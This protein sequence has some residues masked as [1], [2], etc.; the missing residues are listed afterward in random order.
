MTHAYYDICHDIYPMTYNVCHHDIY[1]RK[2]CIHD[3]CND[4]FSRHM[5]CHAICH[6][7][8]WY[9]M[10]WYVMA[11]CHDVLSF[12]DVAVDAY[13][14]YFD[15]LHFVTIFCSQKF[16]HPHLCLDKFCHLNSTIFL[17]HPNTSNSNLHDLLLTYFNKADR[18]IRWNTMLTHPEHQIF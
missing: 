18:S 3:I 17:F 4:I 7:N 14:L 8:F 12:P 13:N 2:H 1:Y 9:V 10:V 15:V 5:I 11:I 6:E 16:A